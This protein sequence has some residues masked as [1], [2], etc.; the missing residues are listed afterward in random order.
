MKL[1]QNSAPEVCKLTFLTLTEEK[2]I[3]SDSSNSL[4]VL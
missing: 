3:V 4:M 1:I 2:H